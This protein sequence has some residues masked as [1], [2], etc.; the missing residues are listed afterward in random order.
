ME[1][2]SRIACW[3]DKMR[4]AGVTIIDGTPQDGYRGYTSRQS[5]GTVIECRASIH[6]A[7]RT[8]LCQFTLRNFS[9]AGG[10]VL[11]PTLELL[12]EVLPAW[13]IEA[14]CEEGTPTP[15]SEVGR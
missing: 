7:S 9:G 8:V 5:R 1:Q 6:R 14:L 4:Q 2:E 12:A 11:Q 10:A 13:E 3:A 15:V